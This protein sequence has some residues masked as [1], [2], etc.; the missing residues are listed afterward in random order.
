MA[1]EGM[2]EIPDAGSNQAASSGG[3]DALNPNDILPVKPGDVIRMFGYLPNKLREFLQQ[4]EATVAEDFLA[5]LNALGAGLSADLRSIPDRIAGIENR[6]LSAWDQMLLP[7]APLQFDAQLAIEANFTSDQIDIDASLQ[8]VASVRPGQLR[9]ELERMFND[10]FAQIHQLSAHMTTSAGTSLMYTIDKLEKN[11]LFDLTQDLDD[12]LAALDPE[13]I[14]AELDK[15][16][17]TAL[18]RAPEALNTIQDELIAAARRF[19]QMI[20]DLNPVTQ[21]QKFLTVVEVLEEQ[22][23][24]LDPRR[25][26]AELGEIHQAIKQIFLAYDPAVFAQEIFDII[27][28]LADSLEALD[29]ATLLGDLAD[30]D[31]VIQRVEDAVPTQ[32]L[33][34]IDSSLEDVGTSLQELDPSAMLDAINDLP[35]RLVEAVRTAIES[36]KAEI[37]AL[38]NAIKY[39]SGSASVSVEAS[40]SVG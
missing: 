30:F 9:V 24:L 19:E 4:L 14:A 37:L 32:V 13:P 40:A 25:L 10:A 8:T 7:I 27:E 21:A 23:N 34:D 22:L 18:Q 15:L 28:A 38:L 16:I 1:P 5:R 2:L 36:I 11:L 17:E 35:D 6:I 31:G 26:A 39:A 20:R 3:T 12:F 29:P 33:A